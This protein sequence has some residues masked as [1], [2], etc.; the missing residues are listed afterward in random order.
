M[1]ARMTGAALALLAAACLLPAAASAQRLPPGV[2]KVFND[3][4]TDGV[5]SP[6]RHTSAELGKT[7]RLV[8]P[9]IEQYA[10]E[11]PSALDAAIEARARG[12]C[13]GD[14]PS[15]EGAAP[16][17]TAT[18]A[19]PA[20]TSSPAPGTPTQT[21]VPE[22]PEP[23]EANLQ[24]ASTDRPTLAE[25]TDALER[26]AAATASNEPPAPVWMLF[27][28]LALLAAGAL[29]AFLAGRTRRGQ[30]S[31]ARLRHSWEEA[32]WR[33]EGTWAEFRDFL[34]LGR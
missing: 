9:D 1:T 31:L 27:A 15:E 17:P 24:L 4:R 29:L 34:R 25:Q 32:T 13:D 18:V 23:E 26:V 22:P 10:P 6:C 19:P 16:V 21:V 28:A 5:I 3:F 12:D 33:A 20:Q 8:P 14:R 11:F 7:R 30:E 2:Q